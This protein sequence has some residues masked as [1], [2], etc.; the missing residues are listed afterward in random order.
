MSKFLIV[1]ILLIKSSFAVEVPV[2]QEQ[3]DKSIKNTK[4][5]IFGSNLFNGGF[6]NS[7]QHRYNPNYLLNIGDTISL[8]LWG[9]IEHELKLTIDQQGNIFVPKIGVVKLLGVK[10]SNMTDVIQTTLV[11]T[12][13]TNVHL[14][15]SLENFQP[16]EVFVSGAISKPGL[17][18]GL[19]SDSILQ[20]LDKAKGIG[21][22][23]SFRDITVLRDNKIISHIDLY[24]YLL[25]GKLNLMQFQ[26][27]DVINV[28]YLKEYISVDI[29][30]N[31]TLQI[32]ID[33]Q[34]KIDN[35]IKIAKLDVSITDVIISRYENAKLSRQIHN[36]DYKGIDIKPND[37]LKFVSNNNLFTLSISIDGEHNHNQ[38]IVVQKGTTL[39]ELLSTINYTIL[40]SRQNISLFRKSVATLQKELLNS[41]LKELEATVLKTGSTTTDEAIIRKQE[42]S[43]VLDFIKRAKEVE[44]KGRV[45]LNS[46]TDLSKVM[47]END[48]TIFIPKTNHIVTVQGDVKIPSALTFVEELDIEEYIKQCGGLSASA[49]EENILVIHQNG[50][51]SR[52]D[53]SIFSDQNLKIKP[54]DSVLVLSKA[55]TKNLQITKDITQILYQIAV[56]AGVLVRL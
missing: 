33:N 9:A 4:I 13:K 49:D 8:K 28:G 32:E 47:L 56:S 39:K 53:N 7:N 37:N 51:V 17:Y 21:S 26:N 29:A 34:T 3:K 19:G 22:N 36:I 6:S 55:D 50:K 14:Y 2:A 54:G 5:S 18:R 43:L 20:F 45:I 11:K 10:N 35:I 1:L 30:E 15:A 27:G 52:Y 40:S 24:E 23:G 16:V 41:S 12:Y 42:A 46:K 38:N 48:D 44:P 31:K 25:D